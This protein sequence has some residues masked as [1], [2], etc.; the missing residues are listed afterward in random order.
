[1]FEIY[2]FRQAKQAQSETIDTFQTRLSPLSINCKFAS[3]DNEFKSQIIQGCFSSR[4]RRRAIREEID[5]DKLLASAQALEL[6]EKQASEKEKTETSQA[7]VLR[8]KP[9]FHKNNKRTSAKKM[10]HFK[11]SNK[12]CRN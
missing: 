11:P 7:N 9:G 12:Q 5:L 6:S 10:S 8:R 4:L 3:V 1:M 2:K